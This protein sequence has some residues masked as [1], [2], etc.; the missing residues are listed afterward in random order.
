MWQKDV[1]LCRQLLLQ[2][3]RGLGGLISLALQA[4]QVV[5]Q[6]PQVC[7][8]CFHILLQIAPL[9]IAQLVLQLGRLRS[10]Q[11][12]CEAFVLAPSPML[13]G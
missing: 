8:S 10:S 13:A 4:L 9:L 3:C 12:P 7:L 6:L 1:Y 2:C 11:A 5:L